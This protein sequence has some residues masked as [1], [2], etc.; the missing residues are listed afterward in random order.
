[1]ITQPMPS[2]PVCFWGDEDGSKLREAYFSMFPGVWR[3][4]DW[5]RI[6]DRGSAV[7]YGRSDSTINR[8]GVRMGTAEIYAAA[9]SVDSVQDALVVDVDDWM[10]LFVVT[11]GEPDVDAIRAAI[12]EQC[13]PRHVP[14][15][16]IRVDAVP[17]TLSRQGA[18]GPGQ[19]ALPGRLAGVGRGAGVARE[20]R[21]VRL[22]RR[23]CIRTR[24]KLKQ[25]H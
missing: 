7:I 18:R 10:P 19:E 13:S 25:H 9:L 5:I 20:P 16:V 1:M 11:D 12:R 17:R 22:V 4:G 2:M 24:P 21:G 6:T 3:H 14:N 15:E 8:G 23:V